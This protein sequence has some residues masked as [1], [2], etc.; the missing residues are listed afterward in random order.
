MITLKKIIVAKPDIVSKYKLFLEKG[1]ILVFRAPCGFG[2]TSLADKMISNG[3]KRV[4]KISADCIGDEI[5]NTDEWDILYIDNLHT[6]HSDDAQLKLCTLIRDNPKKRFLILTRGAIPGW[7][8]PFRLSGLMYEIT[9]KEMFFDHDITKSFFEKSSLQLS[10]E[11]TDVILRDTQ[12]YPL[13]VALV[14]EHLKNGEEFDDKLR[15]ELLHEIYMYFDEMIYRRF[16]LSTRKFLLKLAPF[17]KITAELAKIVSGDMNAGKMIAQLQ[18]DSS[19]ML[20]DAPDTFCFWPLFH[21]FLVWEQDREYTEEQR[22]TL[23][24]R[25]GLFYE[26]NREYAEALEFYIKSGEKNK[27][28]ELLIKATKLHPGMGYYEEMEKYYTSLPDSE[29]S[30]SPSLMQGKSMLCALHADYDGSEKW[31]N[32]LKDFV[33]VRNGTDAA[34]K[35]AKSRLIW[36]DVALPQRG[37]GGLTD[38]IK[39]AFHLMTN[40]EVDIPPFSVTSALPSIMNGG[41]DFSDWSKIDD[42]LYA[43]MRLPVAAVLGRDGI[44]LPECAIAESKFEKGEDVSSK[45]LTLV[46]RLSEVQSNGTPDIEFAVVGLLVRSQISHGRIGDARDA[47]SAMRGRFEQRGLDRFMMNIDAMMCRIDMYCADMDKVEK[48]Y[49]TKA[50]RDS[51]NMRTLK[52]YQYFTEAM[53]ELMLGD[54]NAALLT[55][56]PLEPYCEK[57]ARHIDTIHLCILSAIAKQRLGDKAWIES[58]KRA[59]EIAEKYNFVHTIAAYGAAVLPLLSKCEQTSFVIKAVKAARVQAVYY[60]D[61]LKPKKLS[62]EKL[63]DAEMQVL[64]LI[65]ADKS[66]SE[67][68]E[69][70]DIRLATVKSHVSHILQKLGANRR[71]EAKTI[72]EKLQII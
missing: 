28:S 64:Y 8:I 33:M 7:L 16:D 24:S 2:K 68:G 3:G 57:C 37:V 40:K 22:R 18:N 31:Y 15:G 58:I 5:Y 55:V 11:E 4:M 34:A 36:L 61:F 29:I 21:D 66:N 49:Q 32:R 39:T 23:Y 12:G 45:M 65:C 51:I 48:W 42:L 25:C 47:L 71:S 62:A 69:I 6:M 27:V 30:A 63:T 10:D 41:K 46:S 17:E 1:R 38:T 60:P 20:Y 52:R 9:A 50:P 44:V 54:E 14:G 59:I 56:S 19:M 67:I 13:A 53:A 43:T 35:E 72:A 70:L 26:L